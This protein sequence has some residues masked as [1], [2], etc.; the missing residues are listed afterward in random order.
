MKVNNN[1]LYES[2]SSMIASLS[3]KTV[4]EFER[5]HDDN[6]EDYIKVRR[7]LGSAIKSRILI[8][9]REITIDTALEDR[10]REDEFK[11]YNEHLKKRAAMDML[12]DLYDQDLIEVEEINKWGNLGLPVEQYRLS[13]PLLNWRAENERDI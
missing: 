9:E 2:I 8:I 4:K 7:A 6:P 5:E 11:K 12:S 13:I 1:S 10:M 3:I